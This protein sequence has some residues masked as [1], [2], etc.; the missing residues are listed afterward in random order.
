LERH[1]YPLDIDERDAIIAG[2]DVRKP[3]EIAEVE[4]ILSKLVILIDNA[5][6]KASGP[7]RARWEC[8]DSDQERRRA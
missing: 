1:T 8:D 6:T 2:R 4:K 5:C 3:E 7:L